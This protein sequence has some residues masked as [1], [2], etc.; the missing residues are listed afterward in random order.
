MRSFILFLLVISI[1]IPSNALA[2]NDVNG[3]WAEGFAYKLRDMQIFGG[4][5]NGQANLRDEVKR[6]EF[7]T[8]LVR[9]MYGK[10]VQ[11]R[12]D[13]AFDDVSS[14]GWDYSTIIVAAEKGLVK[15]DGSG[16]FNPES[17]ITREEIVL[18]I[19]RA[20]NINTGTSNFTDIPKTYQYYNEISAVAET[21]IINGYPEGNFGP[22]NSATRGEACAMVSRL[23]EYITPYEVPV[24]TETPAVPEDIPIIT[25]LPA[26]DSEIPKVNLTWHQIYSTGIKGTGA[27]MPG[28]NVIS[29]MWFRIIDNTGKTPRSYDYPLEGGLN[30]YLED[31]GNTDY[32]NDARIEGYTVWP[33]LKDDFSPAGSSKFLNNA[34]A[35][36]STVELM[37]QMIVKYGFHG[38]NLDFENML[39]SDKDMYTQFTKEM[40]EMCREMGVILSVCVTKYLPSGGTWSMCYDRTEL[41]K[42]VDYVALM[43]YDEHGTFS[44]QGG[45]VSSLGWTEDSIKLT[46]TEVPAEKLLLG[47]PFYTR[48][49]EEMNGVVTKTSAIGMSTAQKRVVEAGAEIVYDTKTGQ[50]YAEWKVD[51][52]T[53]KIW[54]E[55]ETSIKA[56]I[57]L[58]HKYNLAGIASWSKTFE[59]P[60][61]WTLIE[62]LL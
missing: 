46:L 57:D 47:V 19:S 7:I 42:Y 5:E 23:A 27:H 50:N 14:N 8:M 6:N 4:D 40:Y 54:L 35:R 43:A 51:N 48:L 24:I 61:T 21:G 56:R 58:I 12:G 28:V 18:M 39:E 17:L 31:Y 3:H 52:T 29:P 30:F 9:A 25:P 26:S 16:D 13:F 2:F 44:K 55:D 22:K 15:G 60:E 34:D 37:R 10:D 36:R 45:S 59:T 49:W 41:A 20:L 1:F 33:M 38:I 62:S 53:F 11:P 32:V